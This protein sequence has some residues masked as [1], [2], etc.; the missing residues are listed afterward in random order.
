MT[1]TSSTRLLT[2]LLLILAWV[3][4][5]STNALPAQARSKNPSAPVERKVV[6]DA[7][8]LQQWAKYKAAPCLRCK[9]TRMHECVTCKDREHAKKCRECGTKKKPRTKRS[10]CRLCGGHGEMPDALVEAPCIGCFGSSVFTCFGCRG[11]GSYPVEG[12]GKKRQKCAVCKGAGSHA[13]GV[14]KGKRRCAAL[15]LRKGLAQASLKDLRAA[16]TVVTETLAKMRSWEP[17]GVK[18]RKELKHYQ[19]ILKKVSKYAKV[20]RKASSMLKSLHASVS[21]MDQYLGHEDR[22][23][24]VFKQFAQYNAFYLDHQLQA[25]KLAIARAEHNEAAA[26]AAKGK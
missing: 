9:K 25:L 5:A 12:G 13:C 10:P 22:K 1:P 16:E 20:A 23:V 15:S 14:C 21:K 26:K 17:G 11:E 2:T 6:T 18:D 7:K 3:G 24:A 4:G 19:A 8:G